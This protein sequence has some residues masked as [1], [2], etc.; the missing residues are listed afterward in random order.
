MQTSATQLHAP[1]S[2]QLSRLTHG[3]LASASF[4]EVVRQLQDCVALNASPDGSEL[5]ASCSTDWLKRSR[6]NTAL[7]VAFDSS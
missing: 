1:C 5:H 4:S 3:Q 6:H 7:P 2:V